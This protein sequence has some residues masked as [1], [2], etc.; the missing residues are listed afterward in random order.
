MRIVRVFIKA[1][2]L[3][4]ALKQEEIYAEFCHWQQ[5]VFALPELKKLLMD[6]RRKEFG[7]SRQQLLGNECVAE[8]KRLQ[9]LYELARRQPV[10][11]NYLAAEYRFSKMMLEVQGIINAAVPLTKQSN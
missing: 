2:E 8:E 6:L 7:I 10:L 5:Q 9:G 3:V 11:E 1:R 4:E